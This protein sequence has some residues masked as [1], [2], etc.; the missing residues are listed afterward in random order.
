M[1]PPPPAI[2][3]DDGSSDDFLE[4]AVRAPLEVAERA[5]VLGAICRRAFLE[6]RAGEVDEDDPEAERFDLV[7]WLRAEG[8]DAAA[9][10]EERRLLHTRVG[11]LATE[12]AAEASWRS[13]ALIALG[14][15]L[16][17]LPDMPPYDAA[18]EPSAL[19]AAVPAPWAA[20]AAWRREATLRP[21]D[22]VAAE[23]ERA[24]L[25]YWR[26]SIADS[27]FVAGDVERTALA[28]A[29]RDV[30]TEARNAGVLD[31]PIR[32]DF[33]A[34]GAAYRLLDSDAVDELAAIAVQRVQ[35]LNWLCGFGSGW[36]DVPLEL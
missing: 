28:V 26:A 9:T 29:V 27:F 8:V 7:A 6:E 20:T 4:I 22:E 35:A 24:E 12:A 15:A 13:E 17:L 33:P 31:S 19:L 25:W 23:R 36:A 2:E 3:E 34:R 1:A 32:D 21:E 16:G 14:W 10:E 18:A 30:T 11:R 5:L